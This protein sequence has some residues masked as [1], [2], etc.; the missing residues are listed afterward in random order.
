MNARD[1]GDAFDDQISVRLNAR[2][3]DAFYDQNSIQ[4]KAPGEVVLVACI[5]STVE[6]G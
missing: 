5:V 6:D 1:D 2:D 4:S 3:G